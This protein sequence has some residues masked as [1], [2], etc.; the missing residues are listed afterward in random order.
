MSVYILYTVGNRD[1]LING[2]TIPPQEQRRKGEQI[3]KEFDAYQDKISAPQ[4]E[5]TIN[6]VLQQ[7]PKIDEV[8]FFVTDQP[9][10]FGRDY[11]LSDTLFIGEVLKKYLHSKFPT[12]KLSKIKVQRIKEINPAQYDEAYK[13]FSQNLPKKIDKS[14]LFYLCPTSG[15]PAVTLGLLLQGIHHF[16]TQGHVLYFPMGRSSPHKVQFPS[17]FLFD[18]QKEV[19][20]H[21]LTN[22][23][24]A[25]AARLLHETS[26][27]NRASPD[28]PWIKATITATVHRL[29]FDFDTARTILEEQA[30]PV[31]TGK[32]RNELMLMS[33]QLNQLIQYTKQ[34]T[35][36]QEATLN[37]L[38]ELYYN[39]Y[40]TFLAGQYIDFLGRLFRFQEAVCRYLIELHYKLPTDALKQ[41]EEFIQG[42]KQIPSLVEYLKTKK[43]E[44][45]TM[46]IPTFLSL[47]DFLTQADLLSTEEKERIAN[48]YK[49]LNQIQ[50]LVSWRNKTII[51]HGWQGINKEQL[52]TE[53][54][55]IPEEKPQ[56][57][58]EDM[59][60]ILKLLGK[61][62]NRNPYES[63]NSLIIPFLE[64]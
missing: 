45:Y 64:T 26:N 49:L 56:A 15:T 18:L 20:K 22:Y 2:E 47:I 60:Q 35:F 34:E 61:A 5:A 4:L 50:N 59:C 28:I 41:K 16:Q 57:P 6:Y 46:N 42:I 48:I 17:L 10:K 13:W 38:E 25:A 62:L 12:H 29:Y 39:T 14:D 11:Y 1:L 3:L 36:N 63:I 8:H 7:Q 52:L 54:G 43:I 40:V 27:I 55:V 24:Y 51:A 23:N 37:L 33:D 58:I 44:Y 31:T 9:E 53:Y 32:V 19:I 30:I 21:F